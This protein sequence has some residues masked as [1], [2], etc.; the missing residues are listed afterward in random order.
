MPRSRRITHIFF[1]ST[2]R[3]RRSIPPITV[4]IR[5]QASSTNAFDTVTHVARTPAWFTMKTPAAKRAHVVSDGS[6]QI[7]ALPERGAPGIYFYFFV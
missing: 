4:A 5:A 3:S 6:A 7:R 2:G 1:R